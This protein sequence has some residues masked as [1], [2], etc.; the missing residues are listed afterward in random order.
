MQS[1]SP[2][3]IGSNDL[4]QLC[5]DVL[6]ITIELAKYI[7]IHGV[8]EREIRD[9]GTDRTARVDTMTNNGNAEAR[10]D[11]VCVVI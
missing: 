4:W 1:A 11:R 2:L 3:R 8:S 7:V 10:A 9:Q 5:G 6:T